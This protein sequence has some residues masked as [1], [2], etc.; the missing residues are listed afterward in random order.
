MREA[1]ESELQ[2]IKA[3]WTWR[4]L[5][6][7]RNWKYRF[8]VRRQRLR[9]RIPRVLESG[10]VA[11]AL[12]IVCLPI[13]EWDFRF[14]RPQQLML[15]FARHG[16]RVSYVSTKATTT[17]EKAPNVFEVPLSDIPN[18]ELIVVQHPKWASRSEEHTSE[19]QSRLHLVCR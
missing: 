8:G 3:S 14:Q 11:S 9:F 4:F 7:L 13:I 5:N 18:A 12:H 10:G 2:A 6:R 17:T 16:Y 1:K 15:Q 19:L